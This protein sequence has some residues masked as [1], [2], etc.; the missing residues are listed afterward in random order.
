M[1]ILFLTNFYRVSGSGGEEQSCQQVVEG[2]QRRGHTTLVL[3]SMHGTNNVPEES[4]GLYRALYLEMDLVP[5]R[6][7][8]TFFTQRRAREARNLRRFERV[9]EEFRPDVVFIWGMWNLPRSLPA[10][11]E[12]KCPG[13]VVYRF[14]TYWPTLPSQHEAYWR[15]P[16]RTPTS[17]LVKQLLRPVALTLLA[18][19]NHRLPLAFQHAICVSAATRRVLVEAG[20]PVANA[21]IIHTGID[22]TP[23]LRVTA[24]GSHHRDSDTLKLLYAGRLVAEKGVETAIQALAELVVGQ[25]LR[26]VQLSV[27]GSA[28]PDYA[29]YLQHLV[30]EAKLDDYVS[31]LDW[32]PPEDMPTLIKKFDV[33]LVPSV[34]PEPFSR[35][36]LEAM[37]SGL[38]VIATP[39]GGTTEVIVD[40]ENGLLFAPGDSKELARNIAN[41]AGNPTLRHRLAE[42]GRRTVLEKYTLER[43]MDAI[44][45]VLRDVAGLSPGGAPVNGRP[46]AGLRS[47][48]SSASPTAVHV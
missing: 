14:A 36:V 34:W 1:R 37:L 30:A 19:D 2:L 5:W 45:S 3:T 26:H 8:L 44:E 13:R 10:L 17:R 46:E 29:S 22:A 47:A 18:K 32:V 7:S 9:L 27:A 21:R 24:N 31:F 41:L 40:G 6:H 20:I 35:M 25:G 33:L 11:A 16:G 48:G 43:M 23:Y 28:F 4:E 15:A 38:A 39:T 42:A 12:A